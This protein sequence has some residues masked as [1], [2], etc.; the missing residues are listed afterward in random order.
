ME[1]SQGGF[2]EEAGE[3]CPGMRLLAACSMLPSLPKL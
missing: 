1:R 3:R 2:L